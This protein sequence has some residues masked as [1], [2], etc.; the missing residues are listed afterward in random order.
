MALDQDGDLELSAEEIA[1]APR[2]LR[3]LDRD[4]DGRLSAEELR[5]P[6]PPGGRGPGGPPGVGPGGPP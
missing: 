3:T 6:R 2:A 1:A 5:P 4:A